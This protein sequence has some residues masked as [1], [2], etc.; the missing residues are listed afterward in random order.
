MNKGVGNGN[1]TK[2]MEPL[3]GGNS[4]AASWM[5]RGKKTVWQ[6]V[7][8]A[9]PAAVPVLL[10]KNLPSFSLANGNESQLVKTTNLDSPGHHTRCLPCLPP[11]PAV[12]AAP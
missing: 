1:D 10:A 5:G 6:A 7:M 9:D 2:K 12:R 4:K 3:G 11:P 8:F